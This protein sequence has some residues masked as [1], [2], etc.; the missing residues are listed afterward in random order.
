M[1]NKGIVCTAIGIA[2]VYQMMPE[3]VQAANTNDQI[4]NMYKN[5]W[6]EDAR[7]AKDDN[8]ITWFYRSDEETKTAT[9]LGIDTPVAD[10]VI[11]EKI[12]GYTVNA[13][14]TVY[15]DL[16]SPNQNA[17]KLEKLKI[18]DTVI[19]VTR[20]FLTGCNNLK[21]IEMPE[22]IF[23]TMDKT[24]FMGCPN[25]KING[26]LYPEF[27]N[28]KKYGNN[29]GIN[30][31]EDGTKVFFDGENYRTGW[32]DYQGRRYYFY[33]SN[34]S[35]AT[36]FIK[37]GNVHYYLDTAQNNLGNLV[38]GWKKINGYWYY[39]SP[40]AAKDKEK[41]Y[42]VTGWFGNYYMY[43]DGKMA[44]GFINLNGSYYY[45]D[46]YSGARKTGWQKIGGYWYYF[47]KPGE[48]QYVGLMSKGWKCVDGNWYYF[49]NDGKM[50]CNTTIGGYRLNSS[51]AW[52]K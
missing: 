17:K 14:T 5:Q 28:I 36:G 29:Y 50:A 25:V 47:A 19:N 9:I 7:Y 44:T 21:E 37:L 6:V 39:F 13:V 46:P 51:G 45:M 33:S 41:G 34:S 10:L 1:K 15:I 31:L 12:N 22:K 4:V 2:A 26:K 23:S 3:C 38:T 35:M 52:V 24:E 32:V 43:S 48:A 42:M 16:G 8:N 30:I 11:P 20:G 40:T 18:P 27:S 49:Y